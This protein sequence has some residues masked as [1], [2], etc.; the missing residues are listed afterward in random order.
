MRQQVT[1]LNIEPPDI[2]P[3]PDQSNMKIRT[4][5]TTKLVPHTTA[6]I[7]IDGIKFDYYELLEL[8]QTWEAYDIRI[9]EPMASK[10]RKIGVL[11]GYGGNREIGAEKGPNFDIVCKEVEKR[12][13]S[14]ERRADSPVN[15]KTERPKETRRVK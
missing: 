7:T 6:T 13:Q 10:L 11:K 3:E 1:V 4:R 9:R 5:V 12:E 15:K 2:G 8:L 14:I